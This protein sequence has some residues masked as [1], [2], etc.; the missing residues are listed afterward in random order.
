MREMLRN[1]MVEPIEQEHFTSVGTPKFTTSEEFINTKIEMLQE[2]FCIH[3]TEKDI[4][5]LQQFKTEYSINAAVKA[6]INKYW[7]V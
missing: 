2:D 5:Y 1:Q 3:L 4:E 6:I 7:E